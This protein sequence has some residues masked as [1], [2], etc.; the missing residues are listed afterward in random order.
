M[1]RQRRQLWARM[2]KAWKQDKPTCLH[3][4]AREYVSRYPKDMYGWMVLADVLAKFAFYDDAYR[5]LRTSMRLCAKDKR[6]LVYEQ[7]G[8]LYNEKCQL[9]LAEKWYGRA[10]AVRPRQN[11]LIYLAACLAKMGR[12]DE[13]I[14]MHRKAVRKKPATA[15]EAYYNLGLIYR[16]QGKFRTALSC[17][18]KAIA[19]D[20]DYKI[21]KKARA[22]VI[23]LTTRLRK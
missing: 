16:A 18:D 22:D 7:L 6:Y 2:M 9:R 21:A 1:D 8:H 15:D 23:E 4:Y 11:N 12:H 13:A 3:Y 5:A 17:L 20:P 10:V 19:I 14:A